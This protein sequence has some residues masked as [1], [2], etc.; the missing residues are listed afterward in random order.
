MFMRIIETTQRVKMGKLLILKRK[1]LEIFKCQIV[2]IKCFQYGDFKDK[3]TVTPLAHLSI[4]ECIKG[5]R[6]DEKE[7]QHINGC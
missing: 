2:V 7:I 4:Y 6:P 5:K 1:H 3:K